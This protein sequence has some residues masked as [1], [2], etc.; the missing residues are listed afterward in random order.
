[1]CIIMLAR[2]SVHGRYFGWLV[3]S[4]V[5]FLPRLPSSSIGSGKIIVEFFSAAICVSVWRYLSWSA[6]GDWLMTSAACFRA[7]DAFCSPSAAITYTNSITTGQS[8]AQNTNA[9]DGLPTFVNFYTRPI[10]KRM[11]PVQF[12]IQSHPL[13]WSNG[14]LQ[15]ALVCTVSSYP[16]KFPWPVTVYNGSRYAS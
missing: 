6:E 12:P 16:R 9:S 13:Y 15:L 1:M 2:C 8:S 7:I 11:W 14:Y 10:Q 3:S 4:Y 5:Y